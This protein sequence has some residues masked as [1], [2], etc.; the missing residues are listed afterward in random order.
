MSLNIDNGS[1][2]SGA[3]VL[4]AVLFWVVVA[5]TVITGGLYLF[6]P[7]L[8]KEVA[9]SYTIRQDQSVLVEYSDNSFFD[10]NASSGEGYLSSLTDVI[11]ANF[12][13]S[14]KSSLDKDLYFDYDI[15]AVVTATHRESSGDEAIKVWQKSYPIHQGQAKPAVDGEVL[16]NQSVEVPFREYNEQVARLSSEL[17]VPLAGSL[18]VIFSVKSEAEVAGEIV[19]VSDRSSFSVPL[20]KAVFAVSPQYEDGRDVV[21]E[22]MDSR[23]ESVRPMLPWVFITG[24]AL[25]AA[26]SIA[27]YYG[28][29]QSGSFKKGSYQRELSNIYRLHDGVI[30]RTNDRIKTEGSKVI[31]LQTFNDLLSMSEQLQLPIIAS[32]IDHRSTQFVVTRDDTLFIYTL[33]R[34]PVEESVLESMAKPKRQKRPSKIKVN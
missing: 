19:A 27:Y 2:S 1:H 14:L 11:K 25:S 4:G 33:G 12:E 20:V 31:A 9:Y 10:D 8:F 23:Y 17:G 15:D 3:H 28:D 26:M 5:V 24:V 18:D 13:Y 29:K 32:E 22:S 34:A 7:K 30:I 6:G 21:V 16:V